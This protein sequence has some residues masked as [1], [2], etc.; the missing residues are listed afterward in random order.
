[1]A[2][3]IFDIGYGNRTPDELRKALTDADIDTVFDVRR[4]NSRARIGCYNPGDQMMKTLRSVYS[5]LA[6]KLFP[7]F[8]NYASSLS[9]FSLAGKEEFIESVGCWIAH[10]NIVAP[11]FLCCELHAY[12]G[13]KVNCHRVYVAGAVAAKLR[14]MT[15]E[16]WRLR[17]L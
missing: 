9:E 6:Y 16:E 14:G 17:H 15:G 5:I 3:T 2:N 13:D 10:N 11:C 7:E 4:K 1:M 8:G 12:K